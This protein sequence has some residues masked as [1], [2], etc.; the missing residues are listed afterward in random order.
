METITFIPTQNKIRWNGPGRKLNGKLYSII[1]N[2]NNILELIIRNTLKFNKLTSSDEICEYLFI[3]RNGSVTDQNI[4]LDAESIENICN[5]LCLNKGV[6]I[7]LKKN[8]QSF[9]KLNYKENEYVTPC[10][11][12]SGNK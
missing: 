8:N 7:K 1:S 6:L 4:D 3:L 5:T 11:Y 10:M 12:E 2:V 9:Y